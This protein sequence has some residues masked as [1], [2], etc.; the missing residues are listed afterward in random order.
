[1]HPSREERLSN[2]EWFS[3][4]DVIYPKISEILQFL[5]FL[6][7]TSQPLHIFRQNQKNLIFKQSSV[8]F[9]AMLIKLGYIGV[10]GWGKKGH[11]WSKWTKTQ[12]FCFDLI[13]YGSLRMLS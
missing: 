7:V 1:M 5:D 8:L 2:S 9:K 4:Y 10:P 13:P 6:T 11:K 12:I 3:C